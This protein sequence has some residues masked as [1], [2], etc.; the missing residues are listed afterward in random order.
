M[1]DKVRVLLIDSNEDFAALFM[2]MIAPDGRLDYLGHASD[3]E[4]GVAAS[5]RLDPDIVVMDV[6][7]SG[8][9]LDG[10]EAAKEI[11]V[12]T[13]IKILLL[14]DC[15]RQDIIVSACKRTFASGYVLKSQAKTIADIIFDT[16]TSDTPQ[17]ELI[18][19]LSLCILSDAE[20]GV[21]DD[22]VKG[23]GGESYYPSP[24][25][26]ANQKTSIFRKLGLKNTKELLKVFGNW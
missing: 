26:R 24:S 1:S 5:I 20:R 15:E 7:L 19:A 8:G 16:A 13:G 14:T 17:K 9:N 10:I 21:F 22:I 4:A 18:K 25:T 3:R 11:R 23:A 12:R 6:N 2:K